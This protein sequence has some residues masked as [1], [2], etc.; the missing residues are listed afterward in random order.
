MTERYWNEPNSRCL[1]PFGFGL[2]YSS[3]E[4]QDLMLSQPSL[5][6][7]ETLKVSVKL[8]QHRRPQGR[9][10]GAALRPPKPAPPA[11]PVREVE[12][13]PP[14][15]LGCRRHPNRRL[16]PARQRAA[17]WSAAVRRFVLETA[18]FDACSSA[19]TRR[20]SWQGSFSPEGEAIAGGREGRG[21][22]AGSVFQVHESRDASSCIAVERLGAIQRRW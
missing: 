4:I 10:G 13:L 19:T 12:G 1:Y 21:R 8:P 2:S 20:Q 9:R 14:R 15:E 17:Y 11:R 22:V 5:K 3:F 16:R 18:D 6:A 7:S